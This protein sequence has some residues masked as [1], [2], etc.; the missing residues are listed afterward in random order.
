VKNAANGNLIHG[1]SLTGMKAANGGRQPKTVKR[2][3][4]YSGGRGGDPQE[5]PPLLDI[6]RR[7]GV[8][9]NMVRQVL[10]IGVVVAV[11]ALGG[12]S[13]QQPDGAETTPD[14]G[15]TLTVVN[16]HW[17]DVS[18]YVVS[19]GQRSH[20]GL[21]A[22]TRTENYE[23]PARMISTGRMISLEADP[24]GAP[25]GVRT[26]RLSIQGGQRVEWTLETGLERSSLAVW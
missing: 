1:A 8:A 22:A 26:E 16:H 11:A 18:V 3:L 13:H 6:P 4:Y 23:M 21:V 20:V 15:W 24:I 25:R 14:E 12:C 17:L 2:Y 10:W 19:D 9:S 7:R 5:N